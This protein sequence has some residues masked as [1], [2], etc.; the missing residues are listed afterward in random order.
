MV[1]IQ[2]HQKII[3][4]YLNIYSQMLL[5]F[6]LMAFSSGVDAHGFATI[7]NTPIPIFDTPLKQKLRGKWALGGG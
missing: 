4:F 5:F 6:K 2:S 7:I 3:Q 1:Y